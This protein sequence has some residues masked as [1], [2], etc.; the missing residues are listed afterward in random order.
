[1]RKKYSSKKKSTYTNKESNEELGNA[2]E[3]GGDLQILK[4][5]KYIIIEFLLMHCV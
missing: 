4:K 3:I 1:M 5:F 2:I